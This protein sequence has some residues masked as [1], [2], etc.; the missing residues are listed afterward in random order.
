MA[1]IISKICLEC[2]NV[3]TNTYKFWQAEINADNYQLTVKWGRIGTIGQSKTHQC[4]SVR[5]AESKLE[6]LKREKLNKGYTE[7]VQPSIV[8][9]NTISVNNHKK[10]VNRV[11]TDTNL[12]QVN[13][14]LLLLNAIRPYVEKGNFNNPVYARML[15]DL[16]ELS[17]DITELAPFLK[18]DSYPQTAFKDVVSLEDARRR[19]LLKIAA[20]Q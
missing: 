18:V 5:D 20:L 2:R 16:T 17:E 7:L 14:A 19:L 9:R 3:F 1:N 12:A 13:G 11:K 10:T 4:N 6:Q 8:K 15:E